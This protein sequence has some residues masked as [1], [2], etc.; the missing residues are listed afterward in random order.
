MDNANGFNMI[1]FYILWTEFAPLEYQIL[2]DTPE[3][4]ET[5]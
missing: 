3:K 5:Y 1:L 4:R 2:K